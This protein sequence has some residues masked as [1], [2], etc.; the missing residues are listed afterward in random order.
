MNSSAPFIAWKRV[1]AA[2]EGALQVGEAGGAAPGR[3]SAAARSRSKRQAG[4]AVELGGDGQRQVDLLGP[5]SAAR[6]T[7]C[8]A[9]M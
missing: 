3:A 7:P 9:A 2:L 8:Q 1:E 5:R 6:P 4:D